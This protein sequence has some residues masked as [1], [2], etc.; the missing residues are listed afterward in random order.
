MLAPLTHARWHADIKPENILRVGD[1]FKLADPGEALFV[2]AQGESEPAGAF[3]TGGTRTYGKPS[4]FEVQF[5]YSNKN[6]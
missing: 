6:D 5:A 3:I 2:I 4:S 1:R